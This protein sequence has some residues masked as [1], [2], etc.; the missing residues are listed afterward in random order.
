MD[1]DD[2]N[3]RQ[4]RN[5]LKRIG[6]SPSG[7]K[8]ILV[9]RL[10]SALEQDGQETVPF[11]NVK[12]IPNRKFIHSAKTKPKTFSIESTRT[13]N[14]RKPIPRTKILL[15]ELPT[16]LHT[17]QLFDNASSQS[18]DLQQEEKSNDT[19]EDG[20]KFDKRKSIGLSDREIK[21]RKSILR[22]KE[23]EGQS[24]DPQST[25]LVEYQR[26]FFE[27]AALEFEREKLERKYQAE[28][29]ELE[30]YILLLKKKMENQ[31]NYI[32]KLKEAIEDRERTIESLSNSSIPKEL[33]ENWNSIK[34]AL[35]LKD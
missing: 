15:D 29:K 21:R 22:R 30:N 24:L 12:D 33:I 2:L 28:L 14:R 11:E 35:D 18:Q 17:E 26:E 10:K 3:L 8:Q 19:T 27:L 34:T 20:L 32:V 4:L 16:Q 13:H 23:E 9:K 25:P 6:L 31:D 5:E 1:P 7:L